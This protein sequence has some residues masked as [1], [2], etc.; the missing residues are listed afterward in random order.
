MTKREDGEIAQIKLRCREVLRVQLEQEAAANDRSVNDEINKRLEDSLEAHIRTDIL[1][2][3]LFAMVLDFVA[4]QKGKEVNFEMV[5][6][7]VDEWTRTESLARG[8]NTHREW[9]ALMN[10]LHFADQQHPVWGSAVQGYFGNKPISAE[11]PAKGRK[12]PTP[13][14]SAS[15]QEAWAPVV[16]PELHPDERSQGGQPAKGKKRT[17]HAK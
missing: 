12:L 17:P 2:S 10:R 8:I 1:T 6:D 4:Q 7:L 11:Q 9:L 3:R 13:V 5:G 15:E 14:A 16:A